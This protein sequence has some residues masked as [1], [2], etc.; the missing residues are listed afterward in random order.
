MYIRNKLRAITP[1]ISNGIRN[2]ARKIIDGSANLKKMPNE[3]SEKYLNHTHNQKIKS[4]VTNGNEELLL[5]LLTKRQANVSKPIYS[6]LYYKYPLYIGGHHHPFKQLYRS[7]YNVTFGINYQTTLLH[8]AV[9]QGNYDMTSY[10]LQ[11]GAAS[12][13]NMRDKI[14]GDTPL[15]IAVR[16]NDIMIQKLLLENGAINFIINHYAE[17]P[18][19]DSYYQDIYLPST[20]NQNKKPNPISAD[21]DNLI[22][23]NKTLKDILSGKPLEEW[24][25]DVLDNAK[26]HPQFWV[27]NNA[28]GIEIDNSEVIPEDEHQDIINDAMKYINPDCKVFSDTEIDQFTKQLIVLAAYRENINPKESEVGY[29]SS[30]VERLMSSASKDPIPFLSL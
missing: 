24:V 22:D 8:L 28:V 2:L 1:N 11:A 12:S 9:L 14:N 25:Q 4:A 17:A 5:T 19:S 15:H 3:I 6:S 27:L 21:K 23:F 29:S 18:M 16:N 20:K 7:A 13:I 30:F 26:L 10:L